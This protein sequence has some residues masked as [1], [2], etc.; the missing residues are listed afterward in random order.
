MMEKHE[1]IKHLSNLSEKYETDNKTI[2]SILHGDMGLLV[3]LLRHETSK[4]HKKNNLSLQGYNDITGLIGEISAILRALSIKLNPKVLRD[5]GLLKML[6][7]FNRDIQESDEVLINYS[8]QTNIELPFDYNTRIKIFRAYEE[9]INHFFYF[10]N[11]KELEV[12]TYNDAEYFSFEFTN[13]NPNNFSE[14]NNESQPKDNLKFIE[15]YLTAL[16]AKFNKELNFKTAV[17]INIPL[18]Q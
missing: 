16:N 14:N 1:L 7:S 6:H 8:D 4:E 9:I 18:T 3:S 15:T 5:L 10:L 2:A 17:T 12:N 11:Y 13:A